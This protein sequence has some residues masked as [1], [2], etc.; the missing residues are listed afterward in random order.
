MTAKNPEKISDA[1]VGHSQ[2]CTCGTII[3]EML[4]N[5]MDEDCKIQPLRQEDIPTGE[6]GDGSPAPARARD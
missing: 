5:G 6:T 2:P 1:M 4:V 3:D